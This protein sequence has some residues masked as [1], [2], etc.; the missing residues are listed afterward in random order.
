M[1]LGL[2]VVLVGIGVALLLAARRVSTA[3]A[4]GSQLRVTLPATLAWTTRASSTHGSGQKTPILG[5]RRNL[6]PFQTRPP[7]GA[8]MD[9]TSPAV[10]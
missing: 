7:G 6:A 10:I 3:L 2:G 1:A 5:D 8:T 4:V 9:I